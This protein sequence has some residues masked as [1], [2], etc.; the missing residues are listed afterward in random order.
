LWR[1]ESGDELTLVAG[2][3]ADPASL[4]K[5]PVGARTPIEGNTLASMVQRTGQ[6]ARM[7]DYEDVTGA[8]ADRVRN[9][10]VRAAVG[11]PIIVDGRLWGLAAVGSITPGPMPPDTEARMTDFADLVTTSIANAAT[12]GEL[13]ASRARIVAAADDARRRSTSLQPCASHT[14][15]RFIESVNTKIRLLARIAFGFRS[16][17]ALIALAMLALGGHRPN[18]PGRTNHPRNHQ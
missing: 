17:Q 10:G 18:L 3:A 5:W 9:V 1:F 6:P 8:V 12:R 7:D 11:V 15:R 14:S 4:A 2:A 16:P 13:L